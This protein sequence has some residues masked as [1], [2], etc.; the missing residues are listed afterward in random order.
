M[1]IGMTSLTFRNRS[2][3][4]V[5]KIAKTAGI[6]GIEWGVS[7]GHAGSYE[8][9]D[10]IKLLSAQEGIE[11]FSLGS[12]CYM[13]EPEGCKETVDMA[14]RLSAPII[15]IW[16]GKKTPWDC[17]DEEFEQIVVNTR[18]MAEYAAEHGIKLGFEY[19]GYSLT[20]TAES[21]VRLVQAINCDNVA[22]YWQGSGKISYEEN[23]KNLK[24]IS[25]YL[26]GIFHVQNYVS[27]E[28]YVLIEPISNKLEGYLAPFK[29]TDYKVLIEF[30]KGGLEESFY[31]DVD[32]LKRILGYYQ[33]RSGGKL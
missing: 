23:V 18:K 30:V 4:E 12:Y 6:D 5:I 26:A 14:A 15:R 10:K 1:K 13:T 20:E 8:N 3:E 7:E 17:R 22:L 16:A 11:I 2:I 33:K 32:V 19:H 25:P 29:D 27:G 31:Q 24:E 9:I 28:G 21:A